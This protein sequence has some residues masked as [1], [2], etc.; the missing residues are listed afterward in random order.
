M[1]SMLDVYEWAYYWHTF[2]PARR[3]HREITVLSESG[4]EGLPRAG[5]VGTNRPPRRVPPNTGAPARD[6]EASVSA[7]A[8]RWSRGIDVTV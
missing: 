7:P 4:E 8:P 2:V 3:W 6:E 1:V 5:E